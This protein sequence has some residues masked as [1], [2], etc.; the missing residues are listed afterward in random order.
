M[1][2]GKRIKTATAAAAAVTAL[3]F[4]GA[5]MIANASS[6]HAA[7][8]AGPTTTA[9]P[10]PLAL[11]Q[12]GGITPNPLSTPPPVPGQPHRVMPL[13]YP[14]GLVLNSLAGRQLEVTFMAGM[15]PHHEAAIA[16]AKLELS[17]GSRAQLKTMAENIIASQQ[18]E[19]DQ[20]TTWLN[21]WYG[22]TPTR[23]VA[24]APPQASALIRAMDSMMAAEI[25]E[26][27]K[28]PAGVRFDIAFM[29]MMTPHHQQA[30]IEAQ[31]A[32]DGAPHPQLQ[33]T[34]NTIVSSQEQE[35]QQM[36][37]WLAAWS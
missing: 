29:Q 36:L 16:M 10:N 37:S 13:A 14:Y 24:A 21:Q 15:I 17:K 31:P 25:A 3:A 7:R 33:L 22:L 20:M 8:T 35:I 19:I 9:T 32:Q 30:I 11:L 26:L 4:G 18:H 1:S 27:A 2:T 28:V 34:A 23:A 5:T 12:R 6:A